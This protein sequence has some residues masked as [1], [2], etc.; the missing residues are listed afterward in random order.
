MREKIYKRA[1]KLVIEVP[2]VVS[3]SNPYEEI[4]EMRENIIGIIEGY[5]CGFC[6]LIDM[7]YKGKADQ[8]SDF[9][10]KY[11]G[12]EEEFIKLCKKL[13]VSTFKYSMCV[14]CHSPIHGSYTL[15]DNMKPMCYNCSKYE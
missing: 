3:G 2:L 4:Q 7:S 9:F 8:W 14:N 6:Y 13:K 1:G 15:D 5:E 12:T 11:S 10:F